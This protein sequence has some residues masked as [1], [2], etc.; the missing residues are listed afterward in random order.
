MDARRG[1]AVV[2]NSEEYRLTKREF[3]QTAI[4]E[5]WWVDLEGAFCPFHAR[6]MLHAAR[7]AEEKGKQVVAAPRPQD[8]LAFGRSR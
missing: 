3:L 8:V 5:G 6:E 4:K 2:A 1:T 7:E